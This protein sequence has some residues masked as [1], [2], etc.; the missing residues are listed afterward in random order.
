M[1]D[2]LR[3]VAMWEGEPLKLTGI[4]FNILEVLVTQT[5]QPVS[6][7]DLSNRGLGRPLMPYDRSIDV[8][9]SSIRQKLGT[10]GDGRSP[11][12]NVRGVGYQFVIE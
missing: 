7:T 11:I 9:V 3:R 5:G 8:H 4:E 1:I 2:P 6:R 10:Y 12:M